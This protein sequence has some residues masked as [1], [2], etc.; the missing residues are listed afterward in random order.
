MKLLQHVI[1]LI[2]IVSN[3]SNFFFD[4]TLPWLPLD[5]LL[6]DKIACFLKHD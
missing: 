4:E 3:Q 6:R 1:E 2:A 5:K